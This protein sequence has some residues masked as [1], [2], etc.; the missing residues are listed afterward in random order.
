MKTTPAKSSSNYDSVFAYAQDMAN[1]LKREVG[2]EKM[3]EFGTTVYTCRMLPNRENRYGWELTC[4]VV[5][6]I[7]A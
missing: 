4:E 7:N 6:P 5:A 2:I 1:S 3:R